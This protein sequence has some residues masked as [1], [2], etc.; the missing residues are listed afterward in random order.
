VQL[1][2]NSGHYNLLLRICEFVLNSLQP[3]EHG[4]G[5]KFAGIL[6]DEERMSAIFESFLRNFYRTE[7]KEFSAEPESIPWDAVFADPSQQRYL[8]GMRTDIT[9]R[10]K[11]RLIIVDAN[12]Y[13]QTLVRFMGGADKVR[14]AHLYQLLAY[15]R[16][17]S[18][19]LPAEGL[20]LYPPISGDELNLDFVLLGHRVRVCTVDLSCPWRD[21]HN[22]LLELLH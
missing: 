7:Q 18:S 2:R 22:R 10:S 16:N 17:V 9:M 8:P 6:E 4:R 3:E 11:A 12:F 14:S 15:L 20:L 19:D 13:K 21:I 1:S 5:S